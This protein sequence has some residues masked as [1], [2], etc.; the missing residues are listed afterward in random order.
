MGITSYFP[1]ADIHIFHSRDGET[2]K[3]RHV[4]WQIRME[5]SLAEP[6]MYHFEAKKYKNKIGLRLLTLTEY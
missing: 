1:H 3:L 4:K 5:N 2:R 6:A